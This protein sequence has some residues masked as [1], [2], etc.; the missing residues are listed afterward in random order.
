MSA[1]L[2]VEAG[3]QLHVGAD[4]DDHTT[5]LDLKQQQTLPFSVSSPAGQYV[6]ATDLGT[7]AIGTCWVIR[8]VLA[9]V[10]NLSQLPSANKLFFWLFD[11]AWIPQSGP[12][13]SQAEFVSTEWPVFT[14]FGHPEAVVM[15][16]SH[17]WAVVSNAD[18]NPWQV[19]GQVEVEAISLWRLADPRERE[20]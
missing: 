13:P 5:K 20:L 18:T 15:P 1:E 6:A 8:R 16:G 14:K 11:T 4:E 12:D 10:N 9:H 3:L 19:A 2:D 17:L 7:P